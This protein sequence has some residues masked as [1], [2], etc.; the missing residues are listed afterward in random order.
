MILVNP[1]FVQLQS[2]AQHRQLRGVVRAGKGVAFGPAYTVSHESLMMALAGDYDYSLDHEAFYVE[3]IGQDVKVTPAHG[4]YPD[5][6]AEY[7][8]VVDD[9]RQLMGEVN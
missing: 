1:T 4:G 8:P 3:R 9:L 5:I 2:L 6:P 7:Q